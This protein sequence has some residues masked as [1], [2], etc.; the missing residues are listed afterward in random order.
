MDNQP[1]RSACGHETGKQIDITGFG[2]DPRN[3]VKRF[4]CSA[5]GAEYTVPFDYDGEAGE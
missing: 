2:E 5:C 4:H 1:D 3:G